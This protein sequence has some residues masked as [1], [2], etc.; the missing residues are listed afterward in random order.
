MAQNQEQSPAK[1]CQGA[2]FTVGGY[3]YKIGNYI[4]IHVYMSIN[5][6]KCQK[7]TWNLTFAYSFKNALSKIT[8]YIY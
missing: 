2:T 5:S 7:H 4:L 1:K 6:F 8:K 3:S